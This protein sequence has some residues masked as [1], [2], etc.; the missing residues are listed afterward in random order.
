MSAAIF[1]NLA[2]GP[3]IAFILGQTVVGGKR[4]GI[5]AMFGIWTGALCHVVFAVVGLSAIFSTSASAFLIVKWTGVVYLAWLGVRALASKQGPINMPETQRPRQSLISVFL[6]GALID[7]LNP[8]VAIFFLAFLPQFIVEGAGP[9]WLQ[10]LFHGVLI[11]VV[12]AIVEPPL[13]LLGDHITQRL[14][15]GRNIALWLN[16]MLGAMLLALA[17]RLALMQK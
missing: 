11:I 17:V 14:R 2:P 1:L 13:V 9:V 15:S 8:K 7:I 4:Y 12:A 6:Q 3:D 16:R 10:L 5:S